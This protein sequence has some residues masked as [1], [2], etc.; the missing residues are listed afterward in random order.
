LGILCSKADRLLVWRN[1][2]YVERDLRV[3]L[4]W[5]RDWRLLSQA[6]KTILRA[7]ES[8]FG[9]HE[10]FIC[11]DDRIRT[12]IYQTKETGRWSS[13]R[14]A[15]QNISK[16]RDNDYQRI[17]GGRFSYGMR[18]VFRASDGMVFVEA[19]YVG[20]ELTAMAILSGDER[21]LED[22]RRNQ[23]PS[24]HPDHLDIHSQIA[25]L[26]FRLNCAPTKEGLKSINKSHLRHIAKSVVFGVCYG[27]GAAAIAAQAREQGIEITEQDAEMVIAAL[28]ARYPQLRK[29][30]EECRERIDPQ[31][32]AIEVSHGAV[33]RRVWLCTPFGRYRRFNVP[34]VRKGRNEDAAVVAELVRQGY[35]FP[36]QSV[37]A[38]CL[39]VAVYNLYNERER[40]RR[41]GDPCAEFYFCLAV[42]DSLILEVKR[43]IVDRFVER[44][45]E[46][47][48]SKNV[49]VYRCSLDGR[50]LSDEP[51]H[52]AIDVSVYEYWA[53]PLT[54]TRCSELGISTRWAKE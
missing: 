42:H 4:Y 26:A 2:R 41:E 47:Q 11:G 38:D 37:V 18:S 39:N 40:L 32:R 46:P 35:N 51:H 22:V 7:K 19:D 21:M 49:S 33:T 9:G 23:L 16:E 44:V 8:G 27:R 48:M 14:P 36:I 6:L 30:F 43:D 53:E 54:K 3:P 15:M 25:V 17:L 45:L 20:A 10:S 52:L 31:H 5:I 13:A 1:G 29:F 12:T 24:S 50:R 34:I 28:F